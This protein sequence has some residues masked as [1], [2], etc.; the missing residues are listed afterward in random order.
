MKECIVCRKEYVPIR[1]NQKC[2]SSKC[3]K[4]HKNNFM[5]EYRKT[6]A[7]KLAYERYRNSDKKKACVKRF[8]LSEKGKSYKKYYKDYNKK[9]RKT[10]KFK[11]IY[12]IC[13]ERYMQTD[14]YKKSMQ[15]Y[16]QSEKGKRNSMLCA[17]RRR[18][19]KNNSIHKWI[20][21]EWKQKCEDTK[22]FCPCCNIPFNKN[23]Y[24]C[25]LDHTPSLSEANKRFKLTG[26]KQIYTIENINP[27]CLRCNTIKN[28]RNLSIKELRKI[29]MNKE[30]KPKHL[31]TSKTLNSYY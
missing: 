4:I 21:E 28:N 17:T 30:S 2:C 24:K 7:S 23:E 8:L 19:A 16:K 25:S 29:V 18:E 12:L 5:K 13:Q 11:S 15:R 31:Y 26:V 1:N 27:L 9:Y 6:E 10:D 3:S 22:G 14:E 20:K